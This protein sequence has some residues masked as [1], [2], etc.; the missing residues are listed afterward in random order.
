MCVACQ[1]E[2]GAERAI[3]SVRV[4]WRPGCP[5]RFFL[6]RA[7]AVAVVGVTAMT[8]RPCRR[9]HCLLA[10]NSERICSLWSGA[11]VPR[12]A[13]SD[14]Y[15]LADSLGFP[16]PAILQRTILWDFQ[17]RVG[18][19]QCWGFAWFGGLVMFLGLGTLNVRIVRVDITFTFPSASDPPIH[20]FFA[21]K[22]STQ[23]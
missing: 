5:A 10:D 17:N 19:W 7:Q 14:L 23:R 11:V 12:T 2:R 20:R 22:S 3:S 4:S 15:I 18:L 8:M 6:K 16:A 1:R 21:R 9:R 13:H